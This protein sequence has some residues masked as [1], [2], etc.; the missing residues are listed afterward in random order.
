MVFVSAFFAL[1]CASWLAS[2]SAAPASAASIMNLGS[3]CASL[4]CA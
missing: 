4:V 1:A 3:A 2:I